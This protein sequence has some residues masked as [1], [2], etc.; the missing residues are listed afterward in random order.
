SP[1]YTADLCVTTPGNML[2]SGKGVS[3]NFA[4]IVQ[5][6]AEVD[7]L[8]DII[9]RAVILKYTPDFKTSKD[10]RSPVKNFFHKQKECVDCAFRMSHK[11]FEII[12]FHSEPLS[13]TEQEKV[14]AL[15]DS[16]QK[17]CR[18]KIKSSVV[19][20]GHFSKNKLESFKRK[21]H[22]TVELGSHEGLV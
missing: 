10:H 18:T 6:K 20:N 8:S 11:G 5:A 7:K 9:K 12:L 1:G 21:D 2:C 13:Q 22:S 19:R 4:F 16:T 15:S 3:S 17:D 14:S